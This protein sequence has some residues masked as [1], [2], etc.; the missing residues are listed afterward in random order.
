VLRTFTSTPQDTGIDAS[1]LAVI[2]D[3]LYQATHASY[4]TSSGVFGNFSIPVCGKT[5]TAEKVVTVG[6]FTGLRD[7]SWWVGWAPCDQ[8]KIVVA[9][10]IENG[11]HGGSAAAPAAAR[12]FAKYFNVAPPELGYIHSD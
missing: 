10:L 6:D 3:G 7:Q 2:R 5:G 11:G 9:A 12:V 1:A 8:P 4:G